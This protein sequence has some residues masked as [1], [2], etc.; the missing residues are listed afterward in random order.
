MSQGASPGFQRKGKLPV[1]DCHAHAGTA[2]TLTAPWTTIADPEGILRRAQEAGIDQTVIFPISNRTYE[3]ANQEIGEICRRYP[4]KFIG[5]AKHDPVSEKGRIRSMMLRE[6]HVLGLRGLKL[7]G[8]PGRETL[9]V[10][11]EL[12]WP[13]LYHPRRVAQFAQIAPA[14]PTVHFILAHLGSDLSAD[15]R[16]HRSAIAMAK[17]FPNVYLDTGAVLIT[18]YLEQAVRELPAEKIVFGSDEPEVDCRMEIFKIRVLDLP[19]EK[20]E[21]ILGGNMLRMLGRLG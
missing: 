8:H 20:E 13:V 6:H 11:A 10:L 7:H 1:V 2:Q 3:K 5:F 17:R 15:W 16:E 4:G 21:L 12:Q 18:R 14:Y 9:D 19:K